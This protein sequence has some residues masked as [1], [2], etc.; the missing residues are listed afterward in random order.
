MMKYLS[1]ILFLVFSYMSFAQEK[2]VIGMTLNEVMKIYPNATSDS[3][4]RGSTISKPDTIYGLDGNWGYRFDKDTLNWIFFHKYI[5]EINETNFKKCLIATQQ[6]IKDFTAYYG[7][8]DTEIVGNTKF[9]DPYENHHWGYNVIETHWKNYKGMKINVQFT[10]MGGKGE[11]A[12]LVQ[13][14]FFDKDYPFYE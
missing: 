3:D 14:H 10:F 13:I 11:Y 7:K 1:A 2:A 5:Y 12:F 9:V 6:I 4:E 8:P